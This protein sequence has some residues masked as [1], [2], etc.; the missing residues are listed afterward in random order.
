MID[1]TDSGET[2]QLES[3][4]HELAPN[5]ANRTVEDLDV[6]IDVFIDAILKEET[7]VGND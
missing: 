5:E 3:D 4:G 1:N 2:M 7:H 6:L